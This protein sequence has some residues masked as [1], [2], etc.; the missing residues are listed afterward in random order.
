MISCPGVTGVASLACISEQ[1]SYLP[2]YIFLVLVLALLYFRLEREPTR[3]RFASIMLFLAIVTAMG[4][5][6][7]MLFPTPWFVVAAVLFVGAV[8]MLVIRK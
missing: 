6:N 7:E 2:G 3:E 8:G 5:V 1:T 4:A